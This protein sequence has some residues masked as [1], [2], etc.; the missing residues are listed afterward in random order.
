MYPEEWTLAN[1]DIVPKIRVKN[2]PSKNLS[3]ETSKYHRISIIIH[4]KACS[5]KI[6][7]NKK[8]SNK[9]NSTLAQPTGRSK[10]IYIV[11]K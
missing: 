2:L 7:F 10:K 6:H 3:T 5:E 9:L 1:L 11:L 8:P 4:L